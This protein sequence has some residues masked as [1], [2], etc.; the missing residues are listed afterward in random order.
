MDGTRVDWWTETVAAAGCRRRLLSALFGA[1]ALPAADDAP[2][3]PACR[4]PGKPGAKPAHCCANRCKKQPGAA[5]GAAWAARAGGRRAPASAAAPAA[6]GRLTAR[7]GR[8]ARAAPAA[9]RPDWVP[10]APPASRR[11]PAAPT[12]TARAAASAGTGV[13]P[14]RPGWQRALIAA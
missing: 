12:T 3:V 14:A 6:A 11:R 7:L 1:V 4:A 10:A 9:A 8:S 2:A 5:M 13:A